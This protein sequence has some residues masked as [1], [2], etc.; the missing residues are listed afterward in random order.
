MDYLIAALVVLVL[1]MVF[2]GWY[3]NLTQQDTADLCMKRLAFAQLW[4]DHGLY[5]R[6]YI[7]SF[8]D[9][10]GDVE[11]VAARLMKNQEDIGRVVE[12]LSPGNGAKMTTLLKEHIGG[13]VKI[14]KNLKNGVSD[15]DMKKDVDAWFVNADE[16][17]MHIKRINPKLCPIIVRKMMH[18][19]L[20]MTLQEAML[21]QEKRYSDEIKMF[22]MIMRELYMMSDFILS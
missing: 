5:T 16:I 6:L 15:D 2:L 9:D 13:A 21:H 4:A 17:T 19:H 7:I 10:R 11:V 22:D 1:L 8:L 3:W 14:L 20:E 18:S 12:Y